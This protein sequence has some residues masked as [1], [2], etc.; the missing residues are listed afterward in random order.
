M[1]RASTSPRRARAF[2]LAA[3]LAAGS[4]LACSGSSGGGT[5]G[6]ASACISATACPDAGAP[7]YQAE[8]APILEQSCIPCH[9]PT[10]PA[11]F[12]MTTYAEVSGEAGSILSQTTA[13]AMP[14]LNGPIMTDAQRITLTAWLRCGAP[15]N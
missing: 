2:R 9:S 7:S 3:A 13:C 5:G 14:P 12:Y 15:D 6:G 10:G 4:V 11:G 8:I 1:T